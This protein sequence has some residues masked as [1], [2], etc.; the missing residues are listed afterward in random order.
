MKT[1]IHLKRIVVA[2]GFALAIMAGAPIASHHLGFNGYDMISQAHAE[3]DGGGKGKMG[4]SGKGSGS[5]QDKGTG[6]HG[7]GS[8]HGKKDTKVTGSFMG[9]GDEKRDVTSDRPDYA[10][11][12]GGKS[13]GGTKPSGAGTKKGDLFGDMLVLVRDPVTGAALT[14]TLM[15]NGVATVFPKAQAFDA[16]GNPIPGV[17]IPRD[18]ATG[19]L[20]TQLPDGTK[21]FSSEVELSRL[22]V[23]RAPVK[24]LDKSYT[25]A[26]TK[27]TASGAV[28]TLDAAGRLVVNGATIDSPLE[29]L[30]LYQAAMAGKLPASITSLPGF[31]AASLL[32]AAADKTNT[33]NLDVVMYLDAILKVNPNLSTVTYDR[34]ATYDGKTVQVLQL[35]PVTGSYD[36]VTVNLYDAVFSRTND[37]AT[38]GA[39]DFAQAVDDAL[40]VI[41]F[42]HDNAVR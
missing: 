18:P 20:L 23:A 24:V 7:T 29:N 12:K 17:S 34:K 40:Q 13:G 21:V 42:I 16:A 19:D 1:S 14:E 26:I 36:V 25:T 9:K 27:L 30:A 39:T 2:T 11:V 5:K 8:D 31:S 28:V 33:V 22:S 10:G 6:D 38:T 37:T 32:A 3:D 4:T 41:E 35:N 15:I